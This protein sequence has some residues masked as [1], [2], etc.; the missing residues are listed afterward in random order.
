MREMSAQ[1]KKS[2]SSLSG[3]DSIHDI[4]AFIAY[5]VEPWNICVLGDANHRTF[6]FLGNNSY[7]FD[8]SFF[9]L[10]GDHCVKFQR[11]VVEHL[12]YV[13]TSLD[14]Y[15]IGDA[16]LE[17]SCFNLKCWHDI[18]AIISLAVDS[19]SSWT[20]IFKTCF[21]CVLDDHLLFTCQVPLEIVYS[22]PPLVNIISVVTRLLWLFESMDLRMNPFQGEADGMTQDRHENMESFQGSVTRS[23]TRKIEKEMQRIKLRRV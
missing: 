10:L 22:I 4:L 7:G 9:S 6:S 20:P 13:L 21:P 8:G 16:K 12:Q 3:Q 15:V 1:K 18:L 14:P 11:E 19:F 17:Q 5:D 23:R 2:N